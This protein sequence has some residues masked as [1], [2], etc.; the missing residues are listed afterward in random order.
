MMIEVPDEPQIVVA[1]GAAIEAKKRSAVS[2][3][4][5]AIGADR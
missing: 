5:S 2:G 4:R 1:L 3:Q